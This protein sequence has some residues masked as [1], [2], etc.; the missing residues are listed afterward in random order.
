M[1]TAAR[2][3]RVAL[4][5]LTASGCAT[6][7]YDYPRQESFFLADTSDTYFAKRNKASTSSTT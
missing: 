5:A 4:L 7:D 2:F 1:K 6:I 3:F